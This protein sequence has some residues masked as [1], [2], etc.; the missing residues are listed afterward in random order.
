MLYT[1]AQSFSTTLAAKSFRPCALRTRACN[2]FVFC[3]FR[4]LPF[5]VHF[6]FHLNFLLPNGLRTLL[7]KHGGVG[8]FF[9]IRNSASIT[10]VFVLRL[11][12]SLPLCRLGLR[13]YHSP[14]ASLS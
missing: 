10:A 11:V 9:P 14:L 8:G 2:F 3:P 4:T 13:E 6:F 7:Q 12:T 1:Q 5:S